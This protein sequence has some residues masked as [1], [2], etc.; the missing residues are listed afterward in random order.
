MTGMCPRNSVR[1]FTEL[2]GGGGPDGTRAVR[3]R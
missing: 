3:E 1:V 2:T